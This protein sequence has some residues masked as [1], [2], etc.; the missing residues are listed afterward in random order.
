MAIYF[1]GTLENNS[2]F[3]GNKTNV[4]ECLK[5]ILRNK[6]DHKNIFVC[7][8][9]SYPP[10]F[11]LPN[12]FYGERT[13]ERTYT[14]LLSELYRHMRKYIYIHLYGHDS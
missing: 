11:P 1:K 12:T 2:V 4:S 10:I 8:I 14:L 6:A 3:L 5:I 13:N 7:C 9:P